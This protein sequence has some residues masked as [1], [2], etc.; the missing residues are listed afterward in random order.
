MTM[1]WIRTACSRDCPDGCALLV[2]LEDGKIRQVKGDPGHPITRGFVCGRTGRFPERLVSKSRLL[3]PKLRRGG[4]L[5]EVSWEEALSR[6]GGELRQSLAS[7]GPESVGF[8]QSG[9]SLGILMGLTKRFFRLLGPVTE[10]VGDICGGAGDEGQILDFGTNESS[11]FFDLRHSRNILLWGKNV[12]V[13]NIHLLPLLKERVGAGAKLFSINPVPADSGLPAHEEIVPLPGRDLELAFGLGRLLLEAAGGSEEALPAELAHR[14]DGLQGYAQCV[15]RETPDFWAAKAGVSPMALRGLARALLEGPC[16][17]LIGWGL[18]RRARG[19]A[20]VRALDALA[21]LSGN[22]GIQGGGAS[23]YYGRRSAFRNDLAPKRDTHSRS[24]SFPLLG[25]ALEAGAPRFFWISGANPIAMLPDSASVARGLEKIPFLVVL[26]SHET[27]TTRR[28]DVVLPVATMLETEDVCGAYGHHW[29]QKMV[30][31]IPPM[32]ESKT[33]LEILQALAAH[34]G[35]EKEMAG[36]AR[37]WIDRFLRKDAKEKG[38]TLE[39]LDQGPVRNP[40]A[41]Q[42]LF[43]DG[44]FPTP[45]GRP[46]LPTKYQPPAKGDTL[47]PLT[48][49]SNSHRKSQCSQWVGEEAE[50]GPVEARLHPGSAEGWEDG[51]LAT[52]VSPVG[53]LGVRLV[54]DTSLQEGIVL[55][56]KGGSLDL[57]RAANVLVPAVETDIGGGAAYLDARVRIEGPE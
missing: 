38:L 56:P 55:V 13:A 1:T 29:I 42:V 19:G 23:F 41:P 20:T 57:G 25:Q 45:S 52:L 50:L 43:A 49:F 26:D 6:V 2:G 11:D 21:I 18:Q 27:D 54:F 31:V 48:L 7:S 28:A 46:Q 37:D 24:L 3:R 32:G 17:L 40:L 16:A 34:V 10:C 39:A 35:L 47:F 12:G 44:R 51:A 9:G 30:P 22:L 5:V 14:V 36:S 53:R 8:L 33:E 4:E 15:F